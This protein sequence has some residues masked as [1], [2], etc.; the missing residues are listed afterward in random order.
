MANQKVQLWRVERAIIHIDEAINGLKDAS[1]EQFV[2][3]ST[4][5]RAT[6]FSLSQIGEHITR[7]Y[8]LFGEVNSEMPWKEAKALRNYIIHD[9]QGIDIRTVYK[10]VKEN[11]PSLRKALPSFLPKAQFSTKKGSL[12]CPF[13]LDLKSIRTVAFS[14][15]GRRNRQKR[16]EQRWTKQLQQ[17]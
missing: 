4:L 8:D 1:S 11:S 5:A 2:N 15:E 13:Q 3:S 9:Y 17:R 14:C 16:K 7:L 6:A 10:T 12:G